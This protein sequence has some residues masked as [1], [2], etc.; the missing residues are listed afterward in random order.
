MTSHV[1]LAVRDIDQAKDYYDKTL[2]CLGY[3]YVG[4]G[5]FGDFKGEA[6]AKKGDQ[7]FSF[8]L[9]QLQNSADQVHI[10]NPA[11]F[12]L[13][14]DAPDKTNVD[15]WHKKCIECGGKDNGQPGPR[16][17]G[18]YRAYIIDPNG[19]HTEACCYLSE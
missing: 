8:G 17:G 13:A 1:T 2:A 14:F 3:N 9:M 4:G 5:V 6:Y 15:E 10:D 7:N 12:H 18:D 19:W 11:G 16:M